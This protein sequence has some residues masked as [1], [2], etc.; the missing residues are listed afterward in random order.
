MCNAK[1]IITFYV[2][3]ICDVLYMW[4]SAL[5]NHH[6]WMHPF[7]HPPI[8]P[9]SYLPTYQ[10]T[11]L[12]LIIIVTSGHCKIIKPKQNFRVWNIEKQWQQHKYKVIPICVSTVDKPP[13]SAS[14][15]G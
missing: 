10:P 13:E 1:H 5:P 4:M 7:I 15:H 2:S 12:S 11:S 9:D 3:A 14:K 6:P 8:L